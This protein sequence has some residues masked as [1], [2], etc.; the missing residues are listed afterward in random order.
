M[1]SEMNRY[2]LT[3]PVPLSRVVA[4][5]LSPLS[6]GPVESFPVVS[7]VASSTSSILQ[8]LHHLTLINGINTLR[9]KARKHT[10]RQKK[11]RFETSDYRD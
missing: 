6:P 5:A 7:P 1:I 10:K 8:Q 9:E 3:D 11:Q 2:Q 4:L